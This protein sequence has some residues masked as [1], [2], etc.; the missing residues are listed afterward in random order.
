MININRK[1]SIIAN[2]NKI[3]E[4]PDAPFCLAPFN[5]LFFA[6]YG[7]IMSCWYNKREPLGNYP[8]NSIDEIWYGEKL[9]KLRN[10]LLMFNFS[11]GCE[12]CYANL[13]RGNYYSV[14]A[15]RYDYLSQRAGNFPSSFEFQISHQCNLE[16]IMCNG[17]LSSG[18]RQNRE[19]KDFY[20]N[21][22]DDN[23][24][25]ML[26]PYLPHL[27]DAAFSGGEPFLNKIYYDI[28]EHFSQINPDVK[29]SLTTNGTILNTR[30]KEYLSKLKFNISVSIDSL[31]DENYAMIRKNGKMDVMLDNFQY[32]LNYTRE[33]GTSMSI[34]TCPMKQNIHEMPLILE[35]ANEQ[36]VP[37]FFNTVVYPPHCTL[38]T[39]KS[40]ILA[41]HISFLKS[42][43][44]K[45]KEN[46]RGNFNRYFSL[47]NQ[48][49]AWLKNALEREAR[50]EKVNADFD[51]FFN[52]VQKNISFFISNETDSNEKEKREKIRFYHQFLSE[53]FVQISEENIK[54]EAIKYLSEIPI[55][56]LL[57]EIEFRDPPRLAER[58]TFSK[59]N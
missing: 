49:E 12:V 23:F 56:R 44:F 57:S 13:I 50:Y 52:D 58:L 30:V 14:D 8:E 25:L 20:K 10:H 47:I 11:Q 5:S 16:C 46:V 2:Y 19:K 26:L 33:I 9:Q 1:K 42:Y 59:F 6:P 28:W 43:S 48:M 38:I 35:F 27:K 37:V 29:I 21:P 3:R 18:V 36:G 45:N 15:Y 55:F 22:Y 32:F 31:N 17:E 39:A 24:V 4:S 41:K 40:E 51:Y 34:K 53:V 54:F 7:R